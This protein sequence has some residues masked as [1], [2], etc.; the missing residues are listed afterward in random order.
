MS[1]EEDMEEIKFITLQKKSSEWG[2]IQKGNKV[3]TAWGSFPWILNPPDGYGT[4]KTHLVIFDTEQ[5][6]KRYINNKKNEKIR[7]G[8]EIWDNSSR[9]FLS[10]FP[11]WKEVYV[12]FVNRN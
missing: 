3:V 11:R 9:W 12:A 6:A 4:L 8:F 5:E 2:A 10:A 7:K 1:Y